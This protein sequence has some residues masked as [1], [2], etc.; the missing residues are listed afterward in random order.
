MH[1]GFS[2]S[3]HWLVSLIFDRTT[4][5]PSVPVQWFIDKL[6]KLI[7]KGQISG[8]YFQNKVSNPPAQESQ[9][10]RAESE[11][12]VISCVLDAPCNGSASYWMLAIRNQTSQTIRE[13]QAI[14]D[15][16]QW[17]FAPMRSP[18]MEIIVIWMPHLCFRVRY[19][20]FHWFWCIIIELLN[21]N[22]NC[23]VEI[24]NSCV[25]RGEGLVPLTAQIVNRIGENDTKNKIVNRSKDVSAPLGIRFDHT[26]FLL[27]LPGNPQQYQVHKHG[28]RLSEL[29][30]IERFWCQIHRES[31]QKQCAGGIL[32]SVQLRPETSHTL[33]QIW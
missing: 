9:D 33:Q 7:S 22:L 15:K 6:K 20:K 27:F 26:R 30:S 18:K 29:G 24:E 28:W 25:S 12:D 16:L 5:S 3:W 11:L 23:A 8:P 4:H 17:L 19:W 32:G 10:V 14:T 31:K 13:S 1:S 21:Q 2:I